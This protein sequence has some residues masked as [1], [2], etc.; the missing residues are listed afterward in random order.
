MKSVT[1]TLLTV[2]IAFG[3]TLGSHRA[4]YD[5]RGILQP[6]T[7]WRDGLARE[8][9]W[10]QRCP[11]EHGYPRF[12]SA[13]FMDGDYRTSRRD[14][15][16]AMQNGMGIISYLKCWR[17][18]GGKDPRLLA[19][20][21]AMG[22]YLVRETL[23]PD[24]GKYPRFTRSTGWRDQFPLAPDAGSQADQPYEIEPDKGGVAG[25]ALVLLYQ[26]TRL[27]SYLD[28]AL[29]NAR[30]LAANMRPGSASASPWPFRADY[31]TGAPRGPVSANMSFILRLFSA[32][33]RLGYPEFDAPRESLWRWIRDVQIPSAAKDGALFVQF[34]EDYALEQNRNAWAPLNLA[35]YLI[36]ER[37]RLD[38]EWKGHAK[39]LIDFVLR[40]FTSVQ[41]GV[42]VCGE[43]DDDKSP[44]GGALSTFGGVLAQYAA[45]TGDRAYQGLAWQALTLC[46]YAIDDDG[47]PRASLY[48]KSRGGWQ[49]DAHT[50]VVHNFVD[51]MEAF[52]EW[53]REDVR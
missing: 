8:I 31:R 35:R 37:E 25:Y 40:T 5:E 11:I 22:D 46:L 41:F 14:S 45:A 27:Q 51:A 10:Y 19:T 52:P 53:G 38:P 24:E 49:E 26:E 30:T 32:L 3:Q 43:Q 16:P 7:S 4:V 15:I 12:V 2:S 47:C 44:W 9:A 28:Q 6:W 34:H 17:W 42:L 1:L 20:A 18:T 13:T 21:R 33:S 23:T 39:I 29:R 50:D 36:E 48:K